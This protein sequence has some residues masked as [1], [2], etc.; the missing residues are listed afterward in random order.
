MARDSSLLAAL[1][2]PHARVRREAATALPPLLKR[3]ANQALKRKAIPLLLTL[4]EG[5]GRRRSSDGHRRSEADKSGA[6]R[7]ETLG[8]VLTGSGGFSAVNPCVGPI[9]ESESFQRLLARRTSKAPSGARN[10]ALSPTPVEKTSQKSQEKR[11]PAV[12]C[13]G[14]GR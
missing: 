6:D 4:N 7:S 2:D 14:V 9:R 5:P 12:D 1:K 11:N 13:R 3:E 8:G 10:D